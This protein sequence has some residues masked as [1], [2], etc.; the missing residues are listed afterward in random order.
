MKVFHEV[1]RL[2]FTAA[3]DTF[4]DSLNKVTKEYAVKGFAEGR[5]L[6]ESGLCDA[7]LIATPHYFHPDY[8]IAA[9]NKGLHVL[10]E[11]PVS[12]TA[13]AAAAVNAVAATKPKQLYAVMFQMRTV[14]K[15]KKVREIIQSGQ[16]GPIQRIHWTITNWFRTQAYYDSGSWRATWAGEGGGVLLNQCP[17][18]LDLLYWICGAPKR[19]TAFLTRGKYHNIEV[20]DDVTAYLEFANG[21]TGTFI[22]STGEAP[23]S[24]YFEIAGDRGRLTMSTVFGQPN[25]IELVQTDHSVSDFCRTTKAAW[26]Q[27]GYSKITIQVP[28]GGSHKAIHQNFVNAILDG[29]KL[30]APA[31]EGLH[32]VEMANA[33]IMSGLNGVP[34]DLPT[35]RE[36]YDRLLQDLIKNSK[37]K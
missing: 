6:I 14:P 2:K 12:V 27:P 18:N 37:K 22:T 15:W 4:A 28:D 3:S 33:M 11:K 1:P 10:T 7:V 30:I 13:K 35:D 8:S 36:V 29:E 21:A 23:G 32:S 25:T 5:E 24:D 9:L 26:G 16:L 19:I 34:V 31:T 17:H 20:E